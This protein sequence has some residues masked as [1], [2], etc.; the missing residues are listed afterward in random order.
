[1]RMEPNT[2][3][4]QPGGN[5]MIG[6]IESRQQAPRNAASLGPASPQIRQRVHRGAGSRCHRKEEVD[7]SECTRAP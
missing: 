6:P 2:Y 1:M 4:V 3:F 7:T 5:G